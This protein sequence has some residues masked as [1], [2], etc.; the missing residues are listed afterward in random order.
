M[1]INSPH[2]LKCDMLFNGVKWE[3]PPSSPNPFG[4]TV[5][6]K[7]WKIGGPMG[8]QLLH[9]WWAFWGPSGPPKKVHAPKKAK[10]IKIIVCT[11]RALT[12]TKKHKKSKLCYNTFH[13]PL[14]GPLCDWPELSYFPLKKCDKWKNGILI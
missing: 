2:W 14:S 5:F 7:H 10:K 11:F 9:L 13:L 6:F 4:K 12:C 8:P 1:D 3:Q